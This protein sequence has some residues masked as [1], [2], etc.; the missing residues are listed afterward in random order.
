MTEK[1]ICVHGHFYQPPREDPI[2]GE[3]PVEAGAA[4]YENWNERIYA[5]CYKP[6]A[7]LGNF[8]RISFNVGPTLFS[9]IHRRHPKTYEKIIIQER[10]NYEKDGVGNGLAQAYNHT[11]LPLAS[12]EDKRT[13]IIWGIADFEHRFGHRPAGL[14]L[15]ETA[16]DEET[17][18]VLAGCG[19]QFT[20]LA[21]WQADAEMLDTT[22]PYWV[23]LQN[24]SRIAVFFYQKTL[25]ERVSFDPG[26]T[27]NADRFVDEAVLPGFRSSQKTEKDR[28]LAIIASDG[29]LY[30]HHQS[31]RDQFL[32]YLLS[33]AIDNKKDLEINYPGAWLKQYPPTESVF[34]KPGTSWSC[35]HGVR[36][37]RDA[38]GCTPNANWKAPLRQAFNQAAKLIDEQFVKA[39][40]QY[41][42]NPWSLRNA[43]IHVRL[44]NITLEQLLSEQN[45]GPIPENDISRIAL[46]LEAQ[47]ERQR[48]FTSCGWFFEDFDRIEPRNNVAYAAQAVWLTYQATKVDLSADIK[49][50]LC[51]VESCR[52]GLRADQV[53]DQYLERAKGLYPANG[54][55]EKSPS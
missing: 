26:S 35:L 55:T 8:E 38:C 2:T 21:P 25:S 24:G 4:P 37:W 48:M 3:I 54:T 18:Q 44:G 50:K 14:W 13:Q 46:L 23:D 12:Y 53:F 22:Q 39:L 51:K 20:I 19:V 36:R 31:F 40:L 32:S 30:G 9:W 1:A 5:Q 33:G 17:L 29:E 16:V 34:I 52:T 6:N 7:E 15:P 42:I 28:Q 45:G 11:I 43:Y 47:F 27:I 41:N 10:K 49:R